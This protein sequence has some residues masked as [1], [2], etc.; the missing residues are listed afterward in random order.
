MACGGCRQAARQLVTSAR[1]LDMGGVVAA[2]RRG[3]AIN[4]DKVRGTYDDSKYTTPAKPATK[5][6][7]YRRPPERTP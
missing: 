7:P 1:R 2:V 4:V 6:T 5:A 3:V